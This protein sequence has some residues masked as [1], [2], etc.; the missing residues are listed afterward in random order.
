MSLLSWHYVK[1]VE[2][3]KIKL[4]TKDEREF[5]MKK[6]AMEVTRETIYVVWNKEKITEKVPTG[7][8]PYDLEDL[9]ESQKKKPD[10]RVYFITDLAEKS[11]A[12]QMEVFNRLNKEPFK[13]NRVELVCPLKKSD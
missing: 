3:G 2:N 4:Y 8:C 13:S 9:I 1:P 12:L 6:A 11:N 7:A 5:D 10:R